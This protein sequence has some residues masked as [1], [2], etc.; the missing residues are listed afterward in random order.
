MKKYFFIFLLF[1]LGKSFSQI[2]K[3]EPELFFYED[4]NNKI[5]PKES[6]RIWANSKQLI[7]NHWVITEKYYEFNTN[8]KP[9]LLIE[10]RKEKDLERVDTTY[11]EY[12]DKSNLWTKKYNRKSS[13]TRDF[14]YDKK[15]NLIELKCSNGVNW[16]YYYDIDNRVNKI[17]YD[18]GR[19]KEFIYNNGT[20]IRETSYEDSK[21]DEI[22]EFSYN[23]NVLEITTK[24]INTYNTSDTIVEYKNYHYD[25]NSNLIKETY[26]GSA[27]FG[28][29]TAITGYR[30]LD[31]RLV[32][33][34]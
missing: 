16:K 7:N 4:Y 20:L 30:Y 33:F 6:K 28:E 26:R 24:R 13:I 10:K 14:F 17:Q 19:W 31:G 25:N 9:T 22:K 15:D 12:N 11:F 3:Q 5:Y 21:L 2:P 8:G 23:K 34:F 1:G 27:S 18:S 32:F 29:V